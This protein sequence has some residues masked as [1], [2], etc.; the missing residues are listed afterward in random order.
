FPCFELLTRPCVFELMMDFDSNFLS[1]MLMK[2]GL[3][4][5]AQI[6]EA[7]ENIG[8]RTNDAEVLLK[9]L[10][11]KGFITPLQSSKVRKNEFASS[12][13]GGYRLVY[14]IASGSFGRVYRAEE[15]QTG[16]VVALKV[17][18][19]RWSEDDHII[20]LFEREGKLGLQLRHLNIV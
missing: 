2:S 5:E 10:E 18:R 7:W 19:R 9:T 13:I 11:R 8:Y 16:R 3:V 14:K 20:D 17:L 15:P 12:V 1:N 4:S 6:Q